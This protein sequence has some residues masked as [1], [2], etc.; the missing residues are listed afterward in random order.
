MLKQS[1]AQ[2]LVF[3]DEPEEEGNEPDS[4]GGGRSKALGDGAKPSADKE[5]GDQR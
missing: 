4:S 2:R 5:A 1:I 3:D